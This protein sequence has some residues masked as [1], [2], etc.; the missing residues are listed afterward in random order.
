MSYVH[1]CDRCDEVIGSSE[2]YLQV[3][4]SFTL[5]KFKN[6]PSRFEFCEQCSNELIVILGKFM[7]LPDLGTCL[8]DKASGGMLEAY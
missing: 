8:T 1:K 5:K 4:K 7:D 3:S 2:A 6:L